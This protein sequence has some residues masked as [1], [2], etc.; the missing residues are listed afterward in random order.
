MKLIDLH[1]H[2]TS[3]DGIY[4]PSEL[5]KMA[6]DAGISV[7]AIADHDSTDGVNEAITAA[8]A[9]GITL[10]PAVELSVEYEKHHDVHLLGYFIDHNDQQFNDKLKHFRARRETRGLQVIA[11]IN[12]K[13]QSEG[14]AI[15][16]SA[17]IIALAEGSL[18]R[19]HIARV[20]I[21]NGL[22]AN[23]QEAF[24]SYL[25]PC[26]VPK[27]YF[28]FKEAI[29]EIHRIGGI[30]VL[31]HPQSITRE[32][33]ELRTMITD[34]AR[35]GLDGIEAIN[36]MGFE[37]DDS[38]LAKL[39]ESLNLIITGGSDFHGGEEGLV[40]GKGRG[41]LFLTEALLQG[42]V[43]KNAENKTSPAQ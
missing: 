24:N 30:A 23:M 4:K 3:S 41:N 34:M 40:M 28:P 21:E 22:S 25:V 7:I 31:A 12:Q 15:I 17:V 5:V 37:G 29:A 33:N 13:L 8:A 43:T 42:I 39:G 36:S 20:L 18:G 14:K 38:F 6:A 27:E 16:D 10:I 35:V 19:P 32:R 11:K 26:N 9:V 2:S 1:L